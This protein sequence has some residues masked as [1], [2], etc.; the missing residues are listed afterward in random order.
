MHFLL[1]AHDGSDEGAAERRQRAQTAHRDTARRLLEAGHLVI[2]GPML[3]ES[4]RAIGSVGVF[5]F[6]SRAEL[7][8]WLRGDPYVVE[9][10][11]QRIEIRPFA[12]ALSAL[13]RP[14]P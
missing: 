1:I 4:G 10:V 9:G 6:A 5:D 7:E 14:P 11:W 8:T 2:G 13:D 3:D 12:P